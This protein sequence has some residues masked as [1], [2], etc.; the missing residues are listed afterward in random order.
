MDRLA[1][2]AILLAVEE[3]GS[4]S[5]GAR[6]LGMPLATV[7]RRIAELEGHLGVR[8]F[9]RSSRRIVLTEPGRAYVLACRRILEDVA[10]AER[11]ASGEYVAPKGELVITAPAVFGRLHVL[12][13]V[14]AF[15]RSFPDVDIRLVLADQLVDLVQDPIDLAVRIAALPDSSLVAVRLGAIRRIVCAS[16]LYLRDR[17]RPGRPQEL[18]AHDCITFEGLGTSHAWSFPGL[19]PVPLRVRLAVNSAEAAIEAAQAGLGLTRVL[20]Y[21]ARQAV[22][23]GD[24]EVLLE[25]F[26]PEA[27]PVQLVHRGGRVLP[28]KLRAFLDFATPRLRAGLGAARG[29]TG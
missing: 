18:A 28:L 6:R 1:A 4:L 11:A 17:G 16:P 8:L 20:A 25:Q 14:T 19:P 15:L 3:A 2:M 12:P 7:S 23:A 21:Q 13:V 5:A 26:E 29:G 24:L 22:Q 9:L 27:V 10:E